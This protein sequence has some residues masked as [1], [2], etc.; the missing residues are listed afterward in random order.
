MQVAVLCSEGQRQEL[1]ATGPDVFFTETPQALAAATA[2]VYVDLLFEDNEAQHL[3][4]LSALGGKAILVNAVAPVATLPP[5]FVRINAWSTFLSGGVAEVCGGTEPARQKLTGALQLLGKRPEWVPD[6]PGMVSARIIAA[7]IN[8][9]YFT[10]S[11]GIATR[12]AIDTAMKLGTAYPYGPF[13]WAQQ[14]GLQRIARLLH[15]LAQTESRYQ[16]CA[17]LL[18][19]TK[20]LTIDD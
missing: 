19:E 7:I 4:L 10:I 3:P 14:I 16:P 11:E 8:E 9:A 13:E 5:P 1:G 15:T 20:G 2:D 18:E 6:V 17:L 12:Q